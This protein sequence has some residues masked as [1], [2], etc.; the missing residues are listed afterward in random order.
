VKRRL[1]VVGVDIQL[2]DSKGRV[3]GR[4]VIGSQV[5]TGCRGPD[6][7]SL[8]VREPGIYA[9]TVRFSDGRT[10][11]LSVDLTKGKHRVVTAGG[12]AV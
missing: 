3:V 11:T 7:A 12:D 10:Q 4:R 1:G 9:L 5:L 2:A 6:A 8:A